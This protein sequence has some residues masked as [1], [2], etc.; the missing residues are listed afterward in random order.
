MNLKNLR[1]VVIF[2]VCLFATHD[3]KSQVE[4]FIGGSHYSIL[5]TCNETAREGTDGDGIPYI[6]EQSE[7]A[8]VTYFFD[9]ENV[10]GVVSI[11]PLNVGYLNE[12]IKFYNEEY[13]RLSDGKWQTKNSNGL[14]ITYELKEDTRNGVHVKQFLVYSSR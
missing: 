10:C 14:Y 12:Y 2:L 5:S 4:D 9:E 8:I 13:S 11:T 6:M 1:P 7:I 3:V